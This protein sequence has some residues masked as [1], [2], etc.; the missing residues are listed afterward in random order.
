MKYRQ[1]IPA[2]AAASIGAAILATTSAFAGSGFDEASPVALPAGQLAFNN[3][4]PAIRMADAY[5]DMTAG[6]HGTFGKFPANFDSGP[7]THTGA[8]HGVVIK[9]V[10]TNPFEGD[11]N[12]PEM[13]AGSYWYVP[14]GIEHSTLCVSDTPCDFYFYAAEKFD[15]IPV[16]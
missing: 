15:F 2:R 3:I 13:P 8:Y 10:M 1:T 16:E 7:H 5:G 14:A 11:E 12:P 9:G 4:N 6:E